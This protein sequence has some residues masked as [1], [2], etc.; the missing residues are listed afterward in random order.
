MVWAA[1]LSGVAVVSRDSGNP[2]ASRVAIEDQDRLTA[3][4]ATKRSQLDSTSGTRGSDL[5]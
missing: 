5:F 1:F 4:G 2:Q 3:H